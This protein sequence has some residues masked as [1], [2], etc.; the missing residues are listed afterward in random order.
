[1]MKDTREVPKDWTTDCD[2]CNWFLKTYG[3]EICYLFGAKDILWLEGEHV[4]NKLYAV[5]KEVKVG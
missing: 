3:R 5:P 4:L 2:N 1:M